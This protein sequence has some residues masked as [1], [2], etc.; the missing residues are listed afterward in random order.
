VSRHL[1]IVSGH[2][3][4]ASGRFGEVSGRFGGIPG[5]IGG[6]SARIGDASGR[7]REASAGFG[8]ASAGLAGWRED[9]A[10]GRGALAECRKT[11]NARFRA[12]ARRALV[13]SGPPGPMRRGLE[14][15]ALPGR[16]ARDGHF[17]HARHLNEGARSSDLRGKRELGNHAWKCPRAAGF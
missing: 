14:V 13:A 16:W 5:G 10:R 8:G 9:F 6:V 12:G 17:W 11:W 7:F 3:G 15:L 4:S 2:I 1:G